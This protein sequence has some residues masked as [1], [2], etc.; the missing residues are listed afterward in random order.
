VRVPVVNPE[1]DVF[2]IPFGK[3]SGQRIEIDP[4]EG[5]IALYGADDAPVLMADARKNRVTITAATFAIEADQVTINGKRVRR[6]FVRTLWRWVRGV[7]K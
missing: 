7:F 3:D 6:G 5:V 4:Y 2:R 1:T